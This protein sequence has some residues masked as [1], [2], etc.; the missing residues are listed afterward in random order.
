MQDDAE[1]SYAGFD[2]EQLTARSG[3]KLKVAKQLKGAAA[4]LQAVAGTRQQR[5]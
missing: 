1:G 5:A 3:G 4:R 2:T